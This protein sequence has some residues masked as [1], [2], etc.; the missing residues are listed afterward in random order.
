VVAAKILF[1][2]YGSL[3]QEVQDVELA[4]RADGHNQPAEEVASLAGFDREV[5][6][7]DRGAPAL[8]VDDGLDMEAREIV[9]QLVEA[10]LNV[11]GQPQAVA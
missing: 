1:V 2:P 9:G 5:V 3:G 4:M 8:V 7:P 10:L 11:L 6:S